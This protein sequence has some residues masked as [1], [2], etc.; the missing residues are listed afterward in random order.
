MKKKICLR[1]R[2][3]ISSDGHDRESDKE[4]KIKKKIEE[5]KDENRYGD[6]NSIFGDERGK[7]MTTKVVD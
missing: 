3:K 7:K 1:K 4:R 2:S 5:I 6:S